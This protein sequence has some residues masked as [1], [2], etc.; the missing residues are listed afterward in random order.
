MELLFIYTVSLL[1]LFRKA[2]HLLCGAHH[3][4]FHRTDH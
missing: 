2:S 4:L 1:V 3:D